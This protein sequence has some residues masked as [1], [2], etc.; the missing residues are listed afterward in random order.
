MY[1]LASQ[2]VKNFV[3]CLDLLFCF[4][5]NLHH[6]Q[7]KQANIPTAASKQSQCWAGQFTSAVQILDPALISICKRLLAQPIANGHI[8]HAKSAK[9]STKKMFKETSMV[10][11]AKVTWRIELTYYKKHSD[12]VGERIH[13]ARKKE[14]NWSN[15]TAYRKE[16]AMSKEQLQKH[17][18]LSDL[19]GFLT[20]QPFIHIYWFKNQWSPTKTQRILRVK[21]RI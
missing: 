1:K 8:N 3:I 10:Q 18:R 16:K 15:Y 17:V 21:V 20:I 7:S 19:L 9:Q 5:P 12:T 2:Y 14:Q 4:V 11:R 6:K 13:Q